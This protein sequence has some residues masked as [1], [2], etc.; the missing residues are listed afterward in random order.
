MSDL[1]EKLLLLAKN[2]G[3]GSERAYGICHHISPY[4]D[5]GTALYEAFSRWPEY[6][7]EPVYPV[8]SPVSGESPMSLYRFTDDVWAGEYG[9]ARLRLVDFL[10]A[11]CEAGRL[12]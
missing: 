6:S 1:L 2:D 4:V 10:I 5:N 8:P 12:S 11:E 9:A 7:G 3:P